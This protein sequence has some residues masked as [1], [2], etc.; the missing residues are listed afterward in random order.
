MLLSF[1]PARSSLLRAPVGGRVQRPS[2][3]LLPFSPETLGYREIDLGPHFIRKNRRRNIHMRSIRRSIGPLFL[4]FAMP[5]GFFPLVRRMLLAPRSDDVPNDVV[6][7]VRLYGLRLLVVRTDPIPRVNERSLEGSHWYRRAIDGAAER[8]E[9]VVQRNVLQLLAHRDQQSVQRHG[10][11]QGVHG[12]PPRWVDALVLSGGFQSFDRVV[13]DVH[14]VQ[15][16]D[17]QRPAQL[18]GAA[19]LP[20]N[21]F[22]EIA[23]SSSVAVNVGLLTIILPLRPAFALPLSRHEFVR[24]HGRYVEGRAPD[25]LE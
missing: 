18:V 21:G 23:R 25:G 12:R 2:L 16:S 10:G 11:M 3:C 13:D 9:Q 14:I 7:R 6:W 15:R 1:V 8:R 17:P 24:R 20:A 19:G 4:S 22:P 5:F